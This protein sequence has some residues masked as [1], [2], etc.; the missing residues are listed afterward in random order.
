M[1]SVPSG[2][3]VGVGLGLGLGLGLDCCRAKFKFKLE[4]YVPCG[5][6]FPRTTSKYAPQ[7][8]PAF[9]VAARPQLGLG[10]P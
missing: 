9:A 10:S 6:G 3:G 2:L 5:H 8:L 4:S 7:I 1:R